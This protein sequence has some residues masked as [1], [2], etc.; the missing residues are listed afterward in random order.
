[1]VTNSRYKIYYSQ[2]MHQ[3]L[4]RKLEDVVVALLTLADIIVIV[5]MY[6]LLSPRATE[7][8]VVYNFDALVV[9]VMAFGFYTR[10]RKSQQGKRIFILNN[11]YEVTAM[12]P[13]VVFAA[14]RRFTTHEDIIVVRKCKHHRHRKCER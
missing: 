5:V 4:M 10:M 14:A 3:L 11:W 1:M 6:P 2:T 13:I 7:N 8:I 9:A 12:I